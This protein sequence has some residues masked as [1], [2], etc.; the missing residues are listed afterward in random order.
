MLVLCFKLYVVILKKGCL[1]FA[2]SSLPDRIFE[3]FVQT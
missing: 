2:T 1:T 3:K